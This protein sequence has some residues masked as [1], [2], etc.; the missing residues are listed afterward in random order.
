MC[1]AACKSASLLF[2][3]DVYSQI[4]VQFKVQCGGFRDFFAVFTSK[5]LASVLSILSFC[6]FRSLSA[7]D[8]KGSFER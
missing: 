3:V 8:I 6:S 7:L 2:P 1:V 5:K 4:K